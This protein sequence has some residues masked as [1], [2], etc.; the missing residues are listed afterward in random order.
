[1]AG[2]DPGRDPYRSRPKRRALPCNPS[3]LP[4]SGSHS[5]QLLYFYVVSLSL[6]DIV[7]DVKWIAP[8]DDIPAFTIIGC[9]ALSSSLLLPF[10]RYSHA[11]RSWRHGSHH[12][13]PRPCTL[14]KDCCPQAVIFCSGRTS[15]DGT[16]FPGSCMGRASRFPWPCASLDAR[17]SLADWPELWRGTTVAGAT[18]S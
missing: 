14:G 4:L 13:I 9:V 12:S 15:L 8:V 6:R 3:A 1:M 7:D 18:L 2:Q 17:C 16:S 11:R 5:N 10:Y